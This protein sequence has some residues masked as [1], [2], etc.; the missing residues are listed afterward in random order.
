MTLPSSC[1]QV[2]MAAERS[3]S[4]MAMD[5]PRYG[6]ASLAEVMPAVASHLWPGAGRPGDA[7]DVLGLPE[8]RGYVLL[9]V[10]GLGWRQLRRELPGLN[11]FPHLLA[12][13]VEL[14]CA[15][16]ATTATSLTTLGTGLPPG[17]H[18]IVGYSFRERPGDARV[19]NTL[20]WDGQPDPFAYQPHPTWFERLAHHDVRVISVAPGHFETSG[21]T[22]A[23]LRG[24]TFDPVGEDADVDSRLDRVV[25]ATRP[26]RRCFVY[27]YERA[28]DHVGHSLGT[29]TTQ[30]RAALT[31]IDSYVERLREL[32]PPDVCLLITGDHGMIDVPRDRQILVEDHPQLMAQV[33]VL[34]GEG[35]LRQLYTRRPDDVAATWR[36]VVGERGEV[37]TRTQAIDRNWFGPVEDRVRPRLGDV[38]VAMRGNWAVMTR[39]LA[40]ELTLVGQHGS[41]TPEEIE[42]P[43]LIDAGEP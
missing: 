36:E 29:N 30:W 19:L 21:L 35:R 12:D 15:L 17:R 13:A 41:L 1:A 31:A 8:A 14:T 27:L 34:A 24:S 2:P 43:L 18:G 4:S 40:H 38:L 32:L 39:A 6:V 22:L 42:V 9:L 28:L 33:D 5:G 10:D 3:A 37:L 20:A 7:R 26:G 11:Y 23:G 25:A 16:P